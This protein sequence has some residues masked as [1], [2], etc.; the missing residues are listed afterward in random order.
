[1]ARFDLEKEHL[2]NLK[3]LEDELQ[4]K[5]EGQL[6][7]LNDLLEQ[8]RAQIQLLND[9]H[10]QDKKVLEEQ[11]QKT[12]TEQIDA[13]RNEQQE[14]MLLKDTL[15]DKAEKEVRRAL[16]E[17]ETKDKHLNELNEFIEK[18]SSEYEESIKDIRRDFEE[19]LIAMEKKTDG[20]QQEQIRSVQE[21]LSTQNAKDLERLKI[22]NDKV[23]FIVYLK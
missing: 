5:H 1:M 19:K 8:H 10:S 9:D 6:S 23:H 2:E 13:L 15:I 14:E 20:S 22:E 17:I 16:Q 7:S 21:M 12:L 3:K 4:K 11:W 18:I